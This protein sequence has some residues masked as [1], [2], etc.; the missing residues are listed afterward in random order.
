MAHEDLQDEINV[1]VQANK[2]NLRRSAFPQIFSLPEKM[3]NWK[4]ERINN[5]VAPNVGRELA[6]LNQ[7]SQKAGISSLDA[8]CTGA[9][10]NSITIKGG[11]GT[12]V[13]H[14]RV[15]TNLRRKYPHY[16]VYGRPV[17][18]AH[19]KALKFKLNCD[20]DWIYRKWVRASRAKN[21]LYVAHSMFEPQIKGIVE[22]EVSRVLGS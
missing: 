19:N 13:V 1:I 9:L 12:R 18:I 17:A 15:G 8:I 2:V 3:I 22:R 5:S 6:N 20:G 10:F 7:K 16:V 14:Y 4:I 21:Y 11:G